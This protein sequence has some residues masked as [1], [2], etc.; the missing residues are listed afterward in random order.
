MLTSDLSPPLGQMD[1]EGTADPGMATAAIG[2]S[3]VVVIRW[4]SPCSDSW[5]LAVATLPVAVY[6][7]DK[8]VFKIRFRHNCF[9]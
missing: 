3:G 6:Q 5:I 4:L 7:T 9:L 2:D 1:A 8:S